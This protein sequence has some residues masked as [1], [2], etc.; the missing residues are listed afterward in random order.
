MGEEDGPPFGKKEGLG[1]SYRRK[2]SG[3]G[4]HCSAGSLPTAGRRGSLLSDCKAGAGTVS[5]WPCLVTLQVGR[6]APVRAGTH[7]RRREDRGRARGAPSGWQWLPPPPLGTGTEDLPR[8]DSQASPAGL[9]LHFS[10]WPED[11]T[12][13]TSRACGAC[14]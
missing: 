1:R 2:S 8:W 4:E 9:V 14:Y 5:W 13:K 6:E 10:Q 7:S 12:V 11:V 3:A